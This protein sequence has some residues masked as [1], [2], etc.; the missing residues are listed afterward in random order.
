MIKFKFHYLTNS[1]YRNY[2]LIIPW[3]SADGLSNSDKHCWKKTTHNTASKCARKNE[4]EIEGLMYDLTS[5]G[6]KMLK[7][8][9]AKNKMVGTRGWELGDCRKFQK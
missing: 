3:T 6:T 2:R 4:P 9:E 1:D 5:M 7:F 8:T